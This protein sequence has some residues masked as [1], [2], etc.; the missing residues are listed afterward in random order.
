MLHE[1]FTSEEISSFEKKVEEVIEVKAC[2]KCEAYLERTGSS[3][4]MMATCKCGA[5]LCFG[6]LNDWDFCEG[7]CE[8][9]R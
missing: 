5:D 1:D 6:C 2:P 9:L 3:F 4:Q 8:S 7:C